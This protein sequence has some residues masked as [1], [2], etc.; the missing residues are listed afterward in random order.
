[1]GEEV[2]IHDV[3][4]S[5]CGQRVWFNNGDESDLTAPDVEALACPYCMKMFWVS[6]QDIDIRYGE[7]AVPEDYAEKG[8]KTPNEAIG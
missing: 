7:D 6:E 5:H 1:M 8:H 3:P 2:T 4:C